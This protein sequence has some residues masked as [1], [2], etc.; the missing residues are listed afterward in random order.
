MTTW[1]KEILE[2]PVLI[3]CMLA[4]I[5]AAVYTDAFQCLMLVLGQVIVIAIGSSK[6]DSPS[7]VWHNS[8]DWKRVQVRK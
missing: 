4:G 7:D 6:L 8:W 3:T 1:K 5:K 2:L